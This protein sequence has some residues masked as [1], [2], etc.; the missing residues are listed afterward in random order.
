MNEEHGDKKAALQGINA[1]HIA[2]GGVALLLLVASL[3]WFLAGGGSNPPAEHTPKNNGHVRMAAAPPA[4]PAQSTPRPTPAAENAT[5]RQDEEQ[6]TGFEETLGVP[7]ERVVRQIDYALVETLL[8]TGYSPQ[9][10]HI[11]DVQLKKSHGELFHYQQLDIELE[12]GPGRF[13]DHL[14]DALS[15]W[16]PEAKLEHTNDGNWLIS[17]HGNATHELHFRQTA[18]QLPQ[19]AK[20]TG[21]KLAVVIDDLG[22]SIK[23]ARQLAKLP[24]PVTFSVLPH[25]PY[26]SQVARVAVE[27]GKELMLHLPMEPKSYPAANPGGGALFT[28]MTK[29]EI[30]QV[31][32]SNLDLVGQASGANN[33]M[34]SKFTQYAPGMAVVLN[35]LNNRG[36]FF[37]DS[38][39]SPG[40]VVAREGRKVGLPIY[41]R[42]VFIDNIRDVDAILRQLKK[43]TRLATGTGQAIAIGHPYPETLAALKQW[44]N[45]ADATVTPVTVQTLKP[46]A[47]T[48]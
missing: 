26:A 5:S 29:Q 42:S 23:Y 25:T 1:W 2:A 36:M 7:L 33:H 44:G 43:A 16:T 18:P 48:E 40:S 9:N 22:R 31:L 6:Y 39:T 30:A 27:S 12:S 20:Q 28:S 3:A 41:R 15:K 38:L 32:E 14:R 11:L 24:Y 4:P 21:A 19:Q 8:F 46:I 13:I 10:M 47:N 34:G 35:E 45:N 17:I 37:L